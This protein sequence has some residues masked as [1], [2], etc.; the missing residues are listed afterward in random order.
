MFNS[1]SKRTKSLLEN[2]V[3][4]T[5]NKP[6]KS[7]LKIGVL[8]FIQIVSFLIRYDLLILTHPVH[9]SVKNIQS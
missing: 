8:F 5:K 3:E 1:S 6:A 7:V 9:H 2:I 4:D